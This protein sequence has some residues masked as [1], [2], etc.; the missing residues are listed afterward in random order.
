MDAITRSTPTVGASG[1][2]G[3]LQSGPIHATDLL[4]HSLYPHRLLEAEP[5]FLDHQR[6]F[7]RVYVSLDVQA[8]M[9]LCVLSAL[10]S[11]RG[12][13]GHDYNDTYTILSRKRNLF[14]LVEA[15]VR[16]ER[17]KALAVEVLSRAASSAHMGL[18]VL[19]RLL[20]P[21]AEFEAKYEVGDVVGSGAYGNVHLCDVA[22][23][24]EEDEEVVDEN[25][26]DEDLGRLTTP[27]C[28]NPGQ[29]FPLSAT[30]IQPPQVKPLPPFVVKRI[31]IAQHAQD[32]IAVARAHAEAIAMI[33]LSS[34]G[35]CHLVDCGNT[36][37]HYCLV[38]PRYARSVSDWAADVR[39]QATLAPVAKA[40]V[41]LKRFSEVV[42]AVGRFHAQQIVHGDLKMDNVLLDGAD[43]PVITDFGDCDF[44][45]RSDTAGADPSDPRAASGANRLPAMLG[46]EVIR[47]P[48]LVVP[49]RYS[50]RRKMQSNSVRYLRDVWAAGCLLYELVTGTFLFA[51]KDDDAGAMLHHIT[52]DSSPILPRD[53]RVAIAN[54]L[55][56]ASCD[57]DVAVATIEQ[58]LLFALQRDPTLRPALGELERKVHSALD[59]LESVDATVASAASDGRVAT[60]AL[61]P[62]A[63]RPAFIGQ[64]E[65][66]AKTSLRHFASTISWDIARTDALGEPPLDLRSAG[67]AH[68]VFDS[69]GT[70]A[71][72]APAAVPRRNANNDTTRARWFGPV[73]PSVLITLHRGQPPMQALTSVRASHLVTFAAPNALLDASLHVLSM[74]DAILDL[75]PTLR[76]REA[77][78]V[79][80]YVDAPCAELETTGRPPGHPPPHADQHP[81]QY[82]EVHPS[83]RGEL[84]DVQAEADFA[85]AMLE[86]AGFMQ[87]ARA[88]NG[89]V[90]VSSF[91][92]KRV[93]LALVLVLIYVAKTYGVAPRVSHPM[94]IVPLLGLDPHLP[95]SDVGLTIAL[96][97]R[98]LLLLTIPDY[99]PR[100]NR[101]VFHPDFAPLGAGAERFQCT[102]GVHSW[103]LPS[104][105]QTTNV[106]FDPINLSLV[107]SDV[108]PRSPIVAF[109]ANT[110]AIQAPQVAA[111][112]LGSDALHVG[113]MT[114]PLNS[115]TEQELFPVGGTIRV[116]REN[117][118]ASYLCAECCMPLVSR[119]RVDGKRW[120]VTYLCLL[121]CSAASG[122][123]IGGASSC[124]ID[125]RRDS[126]QLLFPGTQRVAAA[127]S[128]E[129]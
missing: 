48:E 101:S 85:D 29:A 57:G 109:I 10:L 118:W 35:A 82:D 89:I 14:Y 65:A 114:T 117:D 88:T 12:H 113:T 75:V 54:A 31:P 110:R 107:P 58:V 15:H 1:E 96:A 83:V 127:M 95:P 78:E 79:N 23:A 81:P 122:G 100:L 115:V 108:L 93:D 18:Q 39:N 86:A 68:R 47:A 32:R 90:V 60:A 45:T 121:S 2:A 99:V 120:R 91:V 92:V 43:R 116:I 55:G 22:I 9:I 6:R 64:T 38:M 4:N 25:A 5:T 112:L 13:I 51:A 41:F 28:Q 111:A 105:V 124:L 46:T 77:A 56:A 8:E 52:D 74:A 97:E 84:K 11:S 33:A 27:L 30:S 59:V 49:H 87:A 71:E 70:T 16:H 80:G 94:I 7:R 125:Q 50:D 103:S 76:H 19:A 106:V 37:L 62:V 98:C 42:A 21:S 61:D 128:L 69:A 17:N 24:V 40:V 123:G 72:A 63:L 119:Q 34:A 67:S 44:I 129:L 66:A 53:R 20:T 36:G 3:A 104:G 126:W 73:A 102:C 26:T